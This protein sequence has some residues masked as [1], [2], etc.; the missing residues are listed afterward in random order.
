[1]IWLLNHETEEI[2]EMTLSEFMDKFNNGEIPD[3]IYTIQSMQYHHPMDNKII[4]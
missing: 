2:T 3:E 1:M 4:D